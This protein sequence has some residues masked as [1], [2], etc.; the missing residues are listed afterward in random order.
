MLRR[1]FVLL[2][3]I[4]AL[5]GCANSPLTRGGYPAGSVLGGTVPG[6]ALS[7]ARPPGRGV[8]ILAPL[9]GANA[10]RGQALV[11]A[12]QLAL[13][14]PGSPPLDV[15]DTQGTAAGAAAA[16]GQAIAAG[17]G[18]II[19]PLTAG[20]T[21][22]AAGPARAAGVGVLAFTSDPA[23]AQPGVWVLGI[24]PAQQVRRLV[25]A[26]AAQG[27]QRFAA[28]L[29]GTDFGHAMGDALIQAVAAAGGPP[30]DIRFHGGSMGSIN[31]TVREISGYAGRR[32]PIDAQIKAARA[33]R[34]AEGRR[35]A[36]ELTRSSIGPAP[37]DMLLLADTG[38]NLNAIASLLP[39]YDIDPPQV[40]VIGPALWGSP[41]ARGDAALSGAW[42]AAPDPAARAAFDQ[43]YNTAYGTP[44]PGVADFAFDA[45]AIARALTAEAGFSMAALCRPEGFNGV[46][47]VLALQPDG[48]V[49]RGLAVF[50]L[51]RGG[52]IPVDPAP[53]AI[54]APGT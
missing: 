1:S 14:A 6:P 39:Y 7:T 53:E 30:P 41:Q 12:A 36:A 28:I 40:R 50:E 26:A 10:E 22:A 47:G 42:Y 16:A 9:T 32:G 17:A 24:T 2:G 13:S 43:A 44:A 29:P 33:Q 25:T 19:G 4:L 49:R 45:A 3:A 27:R 46:D 37:F 20:E 18:L 54:A 48:S 34:D 31:S 15:R 21:A 5:A 35:R 38:D 8:A 51:Q 11:R 23:Q 52:P